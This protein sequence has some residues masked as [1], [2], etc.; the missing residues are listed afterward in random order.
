[1]NVIIKHLFLGLQETKLVKYSKGI[2]LM[3]ELSYHCK[4]QFPCVFQKYLS[5]M[6]TRSCQNKMHSFCHIC[7]KVVLNHRGS[8]CWNSWEELMNCILVVRSEIKMK[9]KYCTKNL[10]QVMFRDFGRLVQRNPQINIY[11]C[12]DDVAWA[13]RSL[14]WLLFLHDQDQWFLLIFRR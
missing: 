14:T 11:C 7:G 13:S 12:S 9:F 10:L 8:H 1:M 2:V 3:W 6:H 5:C 4:R